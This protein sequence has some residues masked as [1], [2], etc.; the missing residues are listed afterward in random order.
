MNGKLAAAVVLAVIIA[1][2]HVTILPGVTVPLLTLLLAALLALG[3][4]GGWMAA[5]RA[6]RFRSCPCRRLRGPAAARVGAAGK[7]GPR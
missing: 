3:A 6:R 4:L 1:H 5:R 2:A 7:A